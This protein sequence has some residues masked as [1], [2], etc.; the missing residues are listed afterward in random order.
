MSSS[1]TWMTGVWG[2]SLYLSPEAIENLSAVVG[3]VSAISGAIVS[4]PAE[5]FR[6]DAVKKRMVAAPEHP[7]NSMIRDGVN[8]RESWSDFL[9]TLM[10]N[11]LL[12]GNGLS[13]IVANTNGRLTSLASIPWALASP[14]ITP[15]GELLFSAVLPY[16][17]KRQT[18]L[19][20]EVVH[21]K[22]R[23]DD[24]YF[25]KSP[26]SRAKGAVNDA[27]NIQ[28]N[29]QSFF[30]NA[31]RPGGILTA[32]QRISDETAQRLKRDWDN[33]YSGARQGSVAVLGEGLEWKQLTLSPEDAELLATKV[34]GV[35]EI[36]R[37]YNVPPPIIGD[38]S[39]S[40]MTNSETAARFF[41]THC[42]GPWT[43]RICQEFQR[44]VLTPDYRLVFDLSYLNRA[45]FEARWKGHSMARFA[46]ILT[47][48]EIREQEG[49]DPVS[50][51]DILQPPASTPASGGAS[52]DP[53]KKV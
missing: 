34:F 27:L 26:L 39:H 49:F 14:L 25:G 31:A 51:G 18:L 16:T 44:S 21:L 38:Y 37:I 1:D 22:A 3:C 12:R 7:L 42:I 53:G 32:P 10:G 24:T 43:T 35:Q 40:T 36:A 29:S 45:D 41:A 48:N 17:G 4:L 30:G 15:A 46:G 8:D 9:E 2:D 28:N 52:V 20:D 23:S 13:Q 19:N 47:A 5:V 50:D 11:V 33:S 6:Y